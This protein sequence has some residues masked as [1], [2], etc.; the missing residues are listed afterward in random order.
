MLVSLPGLEHQVEVGG[1]AL[2]VL[3]C[4]RAFLSLPPT[5]LPHDGYLW[6]QRVQDPAHFHM[7]MEQFWPEMLSEEMPP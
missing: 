1:I 6:C 5:S 4:L 2:M 3:L 7:E